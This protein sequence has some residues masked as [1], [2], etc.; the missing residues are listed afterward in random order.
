M[1]PVFGGPALVALGALTGSR[2]VRAIGTF[3]SLGTAVAMTEIGSRSTVPGANDNLSGVAT[4]VGLARALRVEPVEGL[5]VVLV[6]TG[7]EESF[8]EGMQ[9]YAR[10]HLDRMDPATTHVICVDTVGSPELM[11]LEGEGMLKMRDYPEPFKALRGRLRAR[12]R[13]QGAPRDALPQRDGRPPRAQARLPHRH[14]RLDQQ[15]QAA[16]ELP[17]ADRHGR[18]RRATGPCVTP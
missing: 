13:H 14:A 11:Q 17:L 7:S 3:L 10:R 6:S 15:V 4:L 18:Q 5:R 1:F 8:M 16:V 9:G 2:R 12:A